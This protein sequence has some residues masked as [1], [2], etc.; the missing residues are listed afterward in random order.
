MPASTASEGLKDQRV[1][2]AIYRSADT[3]QPVA[4]LRVEEMDAPRG[5]AP[6]AG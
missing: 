2:E 1:V 4:L 6:A 3:G 5:A